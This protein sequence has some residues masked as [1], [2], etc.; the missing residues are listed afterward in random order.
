MIKN[1]LYNIFLDIYII[2]NHKLF[3]AKLCWLSCRLIYLLIKWIYVESKGKHSKFFVEIIQKPYFLLHMYLWM[4]RFVAWCNGIDNVIW[5]AC[6]TNICCASKNAFPSFLICLNAFVCSCLHFS[7]INY[8]FCVIDLSV[9]VKYEMQY[10]AT[11]SGSKINCTLVFASH[12]GPPC[13]LYTLVHIS[14]G[15]RLKSNVSFC[16]L[17]RNA[18]IYMSSFNCKFNK[19]SS[20][21]VFIKTHTN[22]FFKSL[23]NIFL[24][25]SYD[26]DL[27][28]MSHWRFRVL[29]S[30]NCISD[31]PT[32]LSTHQ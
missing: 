26:L 31:F 3:H 9:F 15:F 16:N 29:K 21:H 28:V 23:Y 25:H 10:E 8:I 12:K 32:Y 13:V 7:K 17:E 6:W 1:F 22:K 30:T 20:K 5:I 14:L 18:K 24:C 4:K 27:K 2:I 11:T 19:N